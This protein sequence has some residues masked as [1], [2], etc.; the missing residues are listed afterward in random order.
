[1]PTFTIGL[2]EL[3]KKEFYE[4]YQRKRVRKRA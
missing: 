3:M 1:M 2:A 4:K